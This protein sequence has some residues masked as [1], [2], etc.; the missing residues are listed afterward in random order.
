MPSKTKKQARF[1]AMVSHNPKFAKKVGVPQ[2]VGKEFN[3]ADTKTG[4]LK[5]SE[6]MEGNLTIDIPTFVRVLEHAREDLKD[7]N[8]LHEFVEK[9]ISAAGSKDVFTMADFESIVPDMPEEPTTESFQGSVPRGLGSKSIKL[10]DAAIDLIAKQPNASARY[11]AL[12]SYAAEKGIDFQTLFNEIS[13]DTGA[14][15]FFKDEV[16]ESLVESYK[17]ILNKIK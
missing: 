2:S 14:D 6:Q 7:D 9:V 8:S 12:R 13:R 3:K 17:S 10:V 5:D 1:M 11:D 15:Y 4:I 16:K